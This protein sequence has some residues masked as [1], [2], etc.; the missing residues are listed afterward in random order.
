MAAKE[1]KKQFKAEIKQL[2][3]IITHSIYTNHE[4]FL[5]EL[6]SNASDALDKLRF[7]T[8]GGQAVAD[9]DAPLEIR[10]SADKDAGMLT[11]E[12][13]GLGMTADEL[14]TNI[15]TIAHSGSAQFM[16]E[17]KASGESLDNIIGRFGVGFYSVFMVA[18]KVTITTRSATPEAAPVSW[19]SSGTGSYTMQELEADAPRG[20]RIEIHLKDE[21]KKFAEERTI[22][23]I[24]RRHSNFINFPILVAGE[25]VNTQP[26]LWREPKFKIK[27]EQYDEFYSFLTLDQTPPLETLHIAVDAPVQFTSLVFIPA[28]SSSGLF[29]NPDNYGLDLYVRRVLIERKHKDLIPEYLGF[30]RGLVD[31]E[32]LPLNLSRETLQQN[33]LV[34]K[35]KTTITKQV[36]AQLAKLAEDKERYAEFWKNHFKVFKLGYSDFI[37]RD[38]FAELLRFNSSADEDQKGL[39]SLAEYVARMKDGQ[40]AIY[41]VSGPSREAV[42]LDPHL[43]IFTQRGLEVLYL[44]EPID[45]FIMDSLRSYKDFD[46]VAAEQAD[47]GELEKFESLD[48]DEA[49]PEALSE[50]DS[51]TFEDMLLTIKELL[52][53]R[54]EDVRESKRLKGSAACMVTPDGA[55]SSQMQ[56]YMQLMTKDTSPPVRVMELNRDHPLTRNLLRI[57]KHDQGD[58]FLKTSVEQLYESALL[59]DGYLND[60]HALVG[61]INALLEQASGWYAEIK[62]A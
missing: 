51:K 40:K 41:Y 49:Q 50:E 11:I 35:I 45:E 16:K 30:A 7:L 13:S 32:D 28:N 59:L 37:N 36:L 27:K 2:L 53:E 6:V 4:I 62:K 38:K 47:I 44:Y 9:A 23:D 61:R 54:V 24:L 5:R 15:G 8:A 56:K 33:L 21:A 20:T 22:K 43:E 34:D 55:M 29:D 10:I 57:F 58:G 3:D 60:P 18:D 31:T 1:Q 48:K 42:R 14:V 26:A 17:A 25:Q 19:T 39:N 46:L 12:D 52:G